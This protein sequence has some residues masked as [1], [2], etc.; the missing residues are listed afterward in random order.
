MPCSW[1]SGG[2]VKVVCGRDDV[3]LNRDRSAGS[4]DPAF[5]GLDGVVGDRSFHHPWGGP[6]ASGWHEVVQHVAADDADKIDDGVGDDA[7]GGD[8]LVMGSVKGDGEAGPV[9]ID[10]DAAERGVGDRD[11]QCLVGDQQRLDLLVDP[12]RG[13]GTQYPAADHR[14]DERRHRRALRRPQHAPRQADRLRL[15]TR[16]MSPDWTTDD[17]RERWHDT[18][19]RLRRWTHMLGFGGHFA[20]KSRRYSTTHKALR[21]ARREWRRT[22]RNDWWNR[23][24]PGAGD[25]DD[26]ADDETQRRSSSRTCTWPG[27]AGTPP[28]TPTSRPQQ[29]PAPVPT[30]PSPAKNT[31]PPHDQPGRRTRGTP[32]ARWQVVL[33]RGAGRHAACRPLVGQTMANGRPAA[34][35][36]VCTALRPGHDLQRR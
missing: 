5:R 24:H 25:A 19:G 8:E 29:Q 27:S 7:G 18:Y 12:D 22:T 3:D 11:A 10:I 26:Q 13:A 2:V 35:T 31:P 21:A 33:N 28:P 1:P 15:A 34:R 4:S 30:A 6:Q 16:R 20:T 14:A 9:G 23:H 17:Q 32:D 36:A